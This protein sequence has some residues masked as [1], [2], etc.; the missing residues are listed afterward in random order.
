MKYLLLITLLGSCAL[1]Q[2]RFNK[3]PETKV[4]MTYI[5][6]MESCVFRLVEDNGINANDARSTC[7]A[8]Y[9]RK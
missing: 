6:R 5:D 3:K 1:P 8:I 4:K 7:V 9:R 2:A